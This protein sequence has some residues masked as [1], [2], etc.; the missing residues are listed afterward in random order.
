MNLS[1]YLVGEGDTTLIFGAAGGGLL[2]P[3]QAVKLLLRRRSGMRRRAPTPPGAL[4]NQLRD[5][6]ALTAPLKTSFTAMPWYCLSDASYPLVTHA[7]SVALRSASNVCSSTCAAAAGRATMGAGLS[8]GARGCALPGPRA[9]ARLSIMVPHVPAPTQ[10]LGVRF[11][12]RAARVRH[13]PCV[14]R[15]G[16]G[17]ARWSEA[18]LERA[19]SA[20]G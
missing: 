15:P 1:R 13:A 11:G 12:S 8:G 19:C 4:H 10:Q 17:A 6:H 16:A 5:G 20:P 3:R 2:R 14:G 7:L 18:P 9:T